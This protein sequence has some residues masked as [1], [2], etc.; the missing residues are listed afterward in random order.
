MKVILKSA[1]KFLLYVHLFIGL[2]LVL[3]HCSL[4]NQSRRSFERAKKERPFD[5]VIVPGIP[6][7]TVNENMVMKMRM[8]WAKFLYD[9]GY[10]KNI[11]FSGSAVY[12]PYTE[13]T[14]MKIIADSLGIPPEHTFAETTAEHSTENV[15][16]SWKLAK[17]M[18]FKTIAVASDPYQAGLLRSFARRHCPGV[19]SVPIVFGVLDIGNQT[20][21]KIDPSSAYKEDFVSIMER[22]GFWRRFRGTLGKRVKDEKRAERKAARKA[23]R[24]AK[25]KS[26]AG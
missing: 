10:A 17:Q 24:E 5:V 7:D 13:G 14:I 9:S 19:K 4:S 11:I 21:P 8:L 12:S 1:F 2:G 15:Y 6:F 16:Y 18:G 25:K 22:E 23:K 26:S 20:L 3:T